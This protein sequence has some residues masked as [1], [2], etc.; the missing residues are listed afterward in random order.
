M[1]NVYFVLSEPLMSIGTM[2]ESPETYRI[3]EVVIAKSRS[4]AIYLA[5][6]EDHEIWND[7]R[8]FPKFRTELKLKNVPFESQVIRGDVVKFLKLD[9]SFI[10]GYFWLFRDEYIDYEL[11][12]KGEEL[13]KDVETCLEDY[14]NED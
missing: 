7:V 12:S 13:L 1:N 3:A 4:Q 8:D 5:L 9:K 6:Q 14:N 10:Q 11:N 2:Y